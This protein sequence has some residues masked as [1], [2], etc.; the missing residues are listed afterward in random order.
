MGTKK[1]N[2]SFTGGL[3]FPG[4]HERA[5][6]CLPEEWYKPQAGEEYVRPVKC[7]FNWNELERTASNGPERIRQVM[8]DRLAGC[9]ERENGERIVEAYF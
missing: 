6:G 8:D 1:W 7:C 5:E 2:S 4:V 3:C 9:R